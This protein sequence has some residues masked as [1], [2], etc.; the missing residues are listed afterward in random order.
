VALPGSAVLEGGLGHDWLVGGAGDDRLAGGEGDDTLLG[1][2]GDDALQGDPGNDALFGEDGDDGLLG[3]DGDDALYGGPGE[4]KLYGGPGDNTLDGGPGYDV[5]DFTGPHDDIFEGR[6]LQVTLDTSRIADVTYDERHVVVTL[7]GPGGF[8]MRELRSLIA[9]ASLTGDTDA[10]VVFPIPDPYTEYGLRVTVSGGLVGGGSLT[11]HSSEVNYNQD[12]VF[13][14]EPFL[15]LST[16]YNY[17]PDGEEPSPG[18]EPPYVDPPLVIAQN[19]GSRAPRDLEACCWTGSLRRLDFRK[20]LV[21]K[22]LRRSKPLGGSI[23]TTWRQPIV[24]VLA[25]PRP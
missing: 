22:D 11:F 19:D 9:T 15:I 21:I 3:N 17:G 6:Y 4:D 23:W 16:G 10:T 18:Y 13:Q 5:V 25:T 24:S 12:G 14:A 7:E 2:D 20:C 1:G 8:A